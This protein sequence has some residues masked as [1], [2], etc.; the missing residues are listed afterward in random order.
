MTDQ[1][2][3]P[4]NPR[5]YVVGL[6]VLVTIDDNGWIA[7]EVDLSEL[8]VTMCKDSESGPLGEAWDVLDSH[9]TAVADSE[10]ARRWVQMY[11]VRNEGFAPSPHAVHRVTDAG[12]ILDLDGSHCVTCKCPQ[13]VDDGDTCP[14]CGRIH[15]PDASED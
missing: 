10:V 11:S 13:C 5:E 6:P 8:S 1:Q 4:L 12:E 9:E 3:D 2:P 15:D 7:V 14:T